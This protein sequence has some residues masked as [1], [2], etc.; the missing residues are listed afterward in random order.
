M[1]GSSMVNT[2]F[3]S[4]EGL[5]WVGTQNGLS[6]YDPSIEKVGGP[7]H[8][9][10]QETVTALVEDKT[11]LWVGT[12]GSHFGLCSPVDFLKI[13]SYPMPQ[14]PGLTDMDNSGSGIFHK[15]NTGLFRQ[16]LVG[17]L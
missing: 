11:H 10:M 5:L 16:S 2:L 8:H 4:R 3:E 1:I 15:I 7:D 6:R 13:R 14:N 17:S 9:L 12:F